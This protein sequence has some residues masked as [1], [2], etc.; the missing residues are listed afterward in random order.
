MYQVLYLGLRPRLKCTSGSAGSP[1]L[2]ERPRQL[3]IGGAATARTARVPLIG[4]LVA[5]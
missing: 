3:Q 1:A 4:T 2:G 5:L